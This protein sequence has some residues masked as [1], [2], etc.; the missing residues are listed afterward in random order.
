MQKI[1]AFKKSIL[2]L[3]IILGIACAFL[4]FNLKFSFDFSQFFPEGDEDLIFYQEFIKE[5]GTDDSFLLIAVENDTTVFEEDFLKRFHEFSLEAKKFPYV[6]ENQSLTTLFYPLKTALG[7]SQLPI[8]HLDD[9]TRYPSDWQKIQEDD[10]FINQLIDAKANSL[11]LSLQTKDGLDYE[12]S[13][14]LLSAV[15]NAL[16]TNDLTNSHLLGRVYFYEAL[17]ELQKREITVTTIF[18]TILV[19]LILWLVYRRIVVVLISLTSIVLSL[20]LFLGLLS[21]LGKELNALAAFYPILLLI[22]GTSDVIHIMDDFLGKLK[23][24]IQKEEAMYRALKEVGVSTLLTSVTT[25][26][27]F[28]SLLTSK[29]SSVSGFGINAAIGVLTAF[30]TIIF[31]TCAL[32]LIIDKKY[33]LPKKDNSKRWALTLT[34]VNQFTKG[35]ARPILV[36]SFIFMMLCF[37]FMYQINTNYQIKESFPKNSPIAND[38]D[39]FQKNYSGFRPLEVAV[40]TKGTAKITDFQVAKEIEKMVQELRAIEPIQNVQS[41]NT[42]YKALHKAHNLNKA[43]YFTLTDK[44]DVFEKYKREVKK[45]ARKQFGQFVNAD[46]T[47]ARIT[48]KVLDIGLDSVNVIYEHLNSFASTQTDTTLVDFRLTGTGILLDKNAY[49]VKD[50]LIQGLLMGLLLVAIIMALIFRNWKLLLISLLPN[51]LPLLFAAALLGLFGIPLEAT[52]SV[53]FAIVFGIAVDDTIH[54]LGRY[55]I[56]IKNGLSKEESLKI[57][58][59]ETGRALIITTLILFFGFLVLLFSIHMPSVTIGLLVSV[60]LLTALI[61]DLLLLPVLL[62]KLL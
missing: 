60:T 7:Y 38:F 59:L 3:F 43:A 33:L 16:Q 8:I 1:L 56:G 4:L 53:V 55:R 27:G 30:V 46:E 61:L 19:F 5:F 48:S 26:I 49:Y 21:I 50:S 31:F 24:G 47:R 36:G 6:T 52:I 32:L 45:L 35:Q 11:V 37:F 29:S 44:P 25:A 20:L 13:K 34:K 22:V 10:L 23:R 42:F 62:R 40:S 41:S 12:Q 14:E 18:S 39:F 9:S 15:R 54:F 28:A 57:T 58:F 2:S 51:M 17:V